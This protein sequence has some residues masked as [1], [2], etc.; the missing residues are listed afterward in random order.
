MDKKKIIIQRLK[1]IKN[2]IFQALNDDPSVP[3][4]PHTFQSA[5]PPPHNSTFKAFMG[6][7]ALTSDTMTPTNKF[8][9]PTS[10]TI[11]NHTF[12]NWKKT[13]TKNAEFPQNTHPIIQYLVLSGPN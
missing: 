9:Y 5:Y 4:Y 8:N 2:N 6:L 1:N 7:T 12:M 10:Y 13:K 11:N 3:L